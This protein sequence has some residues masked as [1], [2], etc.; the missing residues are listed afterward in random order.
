MFITVR[1]LVDCRPFPS[2]YLL[3]LSL[4]LFFSVLFCESNIVGTFTSYK[5]N[6]ETK[7]GVPL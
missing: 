3:R 1:P 2:V 7:V 6:K 5:R 4:G